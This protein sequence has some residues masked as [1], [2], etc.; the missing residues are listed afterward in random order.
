MFLKESIIDPYSLKKKKSFFFS[1][2]TVIKISRLGKDKIT[3]IQ[4]N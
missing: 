2:R 1:Q 3:R 4:Y